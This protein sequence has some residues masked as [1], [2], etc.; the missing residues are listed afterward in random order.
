MRVPCMPRF[1]LYMGEPCPLR[2]VGNANEMLT[3]R[4]L[5]LPTGVTRVAFQW[6]VTVRTVEFELGCAHYL[7]STM[8]DQPAKSISIFS[9]FILFPKG[10]RKSHSAMPSAQ[11]REAALFRAAAE[12]PP[13]PARR[14]F[15]DQ[16]CADG[17]SFGCPRMSRRFSR[18]H[19]D[20]LAASLPLTEA[21]ALL[22]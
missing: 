6:L 21:R 4:A 16:A 13:G 1:R 5:N 18:T 7:H 22:K 9:I 20:W 3:R 12:L 2:W 8:R 17:S 15:L 19:G 14:A 11:E 10:M